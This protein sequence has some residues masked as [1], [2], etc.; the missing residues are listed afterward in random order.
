MKSKLFRLDKNDFIKG[1]IVTVVTAVL[2]ALLKVIET[3][4]LEFNMAN[5]KVIATVAIT[6]GISY[7]LKN[8]A[9]NSEDKILK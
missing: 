2:T 3:G 1:L 9:S 5:A 7:I 4:G 8:F 6:A